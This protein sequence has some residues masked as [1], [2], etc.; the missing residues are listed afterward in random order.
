VLGGVLEDTVALV[1]R[2]HQRPL[3]LDRETAQ[4]VLQ[5][6]AEEPLKANG[7]LAS[8]VHV[9]V[10]TADLLTDRMESLNTRHYIT[11]RISINGLLTRQSL[12]FKLDLS[13]FTNCNELND[14]LQDKFNIPAFQ[15]RLLQRLSIFSFKMLNFVSAAK[16][17]KEMI[18][19]K[20]HELKSQETN[21]A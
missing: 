9:E 14:Y 21:N 11:P 6:T 19:T 2:A 16:I 10:A 13:Q 5:L 1:A 3:R 4:R 15:H 12:L 17:L 18:E 7:V 8:V 20:F